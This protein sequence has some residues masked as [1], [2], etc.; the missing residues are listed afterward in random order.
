LIA[1]I[2][3]DESDVLGVKGWAE[4]KEESYEKMKNPN[5]SD[6]ADRGMWFRKWPPQALFRNGKE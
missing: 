1:I 3:R 6:Q 5:W 2:V 4:N